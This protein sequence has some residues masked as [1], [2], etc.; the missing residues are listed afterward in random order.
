LAIISDSGLVSARSGVAFK[1]G[2]PT[3]LF[4]PFELLYPLFSSGGHVQDVGDELRQHPG[5]D[6]PTMIIQ[7]TGDARVD[8]HNGPELARLTHGVLWL[9]PGVPH[10]GAF[11]H[12]PGKYVS[13]VNAFIRRAESMA[14]P[15]P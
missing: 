15:S 8:W 6:V 10:V 2:L 14:R 3:S 13:R 11:R 12:D 7:G 4:G 9:L 5:Y 1:S